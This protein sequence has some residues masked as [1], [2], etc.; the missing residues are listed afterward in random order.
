MQP[1]IY[2]FT[3]GTTPLLISIPHAGTG[4][5]EAIGRRLTPAAQALPD[6]DWHLDRLYEFVT[7]L[8]AAKL[9]ATHS[10][11]VV[12]LNRPPDDTRLYQTASTGL[13][14]EMQFNG[15]NIYRG[16]AP[17]AEERGRRLEQFYEPYH[18]KIRETLEITKSRFGF[19]VLFDAHSIRS[20][21]PR[22]FEGRLADLNI[23]TNG[24]AS[25]AESLATA[26]IDTCQSSDYT[27][28]VNGR[29]KGGHITRYYG[30]P[31]AGIH[32]IQLELAQ[33]NYMDEDG[34][35][36]FDEAKACALNEHVLRPLIKALIEWTPA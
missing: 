10:R 6:T 2:E 9:V 27:T 12:D 16:D 3:S 36:Q 1:S 7:G 5:P 35:N 29:F 21:V 26:A 4:V 30:Q 24:G 15:A 11:Y 33:R 20:R 23:G 22:L 32:A 31:E 14:P 8:G 19:A 17:N 25:A 13:I 34:S 18:A 28:V